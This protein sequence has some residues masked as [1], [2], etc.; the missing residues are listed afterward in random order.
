MQAPKSNRA[1]SAGR[2]M[3]GGRLASTV[4]AALPLGVAVI[5]ADARLSFWN[6]QAAMLFGVPPLMAAETPLLSEIL[7]SVASLTPRQCDE[8]IEFAATHITAG[9]R[10]EP[11]SCLRISLGR[12]H[13]IAIQVCGIGSGQWMLVIDDGKLAEAAGP[14]GPP[15]GT[16][17]WL[18]PLTGLHNR[19][20]FNRV[21]RDLVDNAVSTPGDVVLPGSTVL[22]IDL[23]R[24]KAINDTLGYPIGDALLCL[25]ARRLRREAREEDL[26]VRLGGDEFVILIANGER[27]EPLA[28]RVVEVLSR[29]F[30][31]EGHIANIGASVGIARVREHGTSADDLMRYAELALYDAKSA[32]GGAWR[33]FD[34]T[35]AA[36]AQVRRDLETGLR[37]ALTMGELSL[38]YQPQLNVHTQRLT[39][40]E[41]LLRWNHP[42]LGQ[43][44]PAVFIPVAEEIGC[45]G[46]MGE[47]VLR[48]ACQE[49]T[50]WPAPLSVAVNVSPRQLEDS[51]RLANTVLA[52]LE[53]SGLA[54][55]RLEI[56]ITESAL[57]STDP[58]VLKTLHRLRASGIHIAMDDFGTGY[59]SLS[60]LRSFPFDKIKI[61]RS[62]VADLGVDAEAA[63]VIRA[64]AALGA[65]LGM[66]TIA[67]GVETADQAAL[68]GA[69]GCTDIPGYLISRP[70]QA[71][72]IDAFLSRYA[73]AS[74]N[75]STAA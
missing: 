64:I 43:I 63:A 15:Q 6:E 21:L 45:I 32:G 17:A 33:V 20:H 52:A 35:M 10:T 11:E 5:D 65:G 58:H 16:V 66:T 13:R 4:L 73:L 9:D 72:E 42:T 8:I 3:A 41:A 70:I 40:F 30:L 19:R 2:G 47:W 14:T 25:V 1:V 7:T 46:A 44:S 39:G 49:A 56:E 23:D 68:V 51:E 74:D 26:L 69:H 48:T 29:P 38:V 50:R 28:T 22:M 59:S 12:D 54:P 53:A 61:D 55:E 34:P 24:F 71:P 31:V 18:D 67:E 36:Q 57:L 60:Q 37:T 27:A 75:F 62:F